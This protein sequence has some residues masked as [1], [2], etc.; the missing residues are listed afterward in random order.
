[1]QLEI[2]YSLCNLFALPSYSNE[3]PYNSEGYLLQ[4]LAIKVIVSFFFFFTEKEE[5]SKKKKKK[6]KDKM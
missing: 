3:S 5:E 2:F 1:M 6:V 4:L